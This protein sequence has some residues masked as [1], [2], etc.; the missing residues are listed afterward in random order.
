M[1]GRMPS[2]LRRLGAHPRLEPV[3]AAGLRARGV[4][5]SLRFFAG[6]AT[7]R[8][9]GEYVLRSN[10]ARLHIVHGTSD[11]ATMDQA[12]MQGVYTPTPEADA[13][14]RA[15]GRPPVILDLG[16][17]VGLFSIWAALR[18]PGA[19]TISVEPLPRNVELLRRNLALALG[20]GEHEVVAAAAT[21]ADGEVTFGD[22]AQFSMGRVVDGG[23]GVTVP[24]RDVFDLIGDGVDLLKVDIE[25]AEWPIV[26]DPRFSAAL[27]PVIMFEHHP[28]G[29][30]AGATPEASAAAVLDRAGYAARQTVVEGPGAGIFWGVRR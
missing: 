20:E 24:S 27:A 12:F 10:G 13:A 17:N 11:A 2:A 28:H 9:E 14:L 8:G 19:R 22:V 15:L 4:R 18:W 1:V 5:P 29:A 21:T 7:G 30:P 25:G 6:E 26:A 23:E 3:V 16:A